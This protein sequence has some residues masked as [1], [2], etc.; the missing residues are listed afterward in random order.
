MSI[1]YVPDTVLGLENCGKPKTVLTELLLSW[2]WRRFAEI[3]R[4]TVV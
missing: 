3:M 2:W 4:N 1:Y